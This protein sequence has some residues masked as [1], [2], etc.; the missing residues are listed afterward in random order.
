MTNKRVA[1]LHTFWSY[2]LA[3][4]PETRR[5]M[6]AMRALSS[7]D[8]TPASSLESELE[9]PFVDARCLVFGVVYIHVT[10]IQR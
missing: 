9:L 1:F 10:V 2:L 3:E 5:L 6:R 7:E 4:A 8:R